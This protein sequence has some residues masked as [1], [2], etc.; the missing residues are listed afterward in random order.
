MLGPEEL[1]GAVDGQ[2]FCFVDVLAA[3]VPPFARVAFGILVGENAALDLHNGRAGEVFAG[4]ELDVL[5]LAQT[6]M[7]YDFGDLRI[8]GGE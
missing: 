7:A 5:E 2:D 4:D 3:P 8:N 1:L 6:F